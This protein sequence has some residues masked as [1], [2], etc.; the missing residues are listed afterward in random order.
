MPRLLACL[1]VL[2]AGTLS[3]DG[4]AMLELDLPLSNGRLFGAAFAQISPGERPCC[5]NDFSDKGHGKRVPGP[6]ASET[7]QGDPFATGAAGDPFATD[8]GGD[9]FAG[10]PAFQND[11]GGQVSNS[12]ESEAPNRFGWSMDFHGYLESRNQLRTTDGEF[13]SAR[14]RLWM[15][16]DG[17][18]GED[19]EG[20]AF[21]GSARFFVSAALDIDPS[22]ADLSDDHSAVRP[23]IQE[24]Y[25][26]F[27]SGRADFTLGRKMVRWGT[28][29]GVNPMDLINPLDYRD[30]VASGRSD[31]RVPVF[32]GQGIFRLP[33]S[34]LLQEAS[35]ECVAIPLARVNKLNSPGSAWESPWLQTLRE[36]D[37][38]GLLVFESQQR[39][40][41]V[42]KDAEFGFRMSSVFSGWDLSLLGFYG[43]LDNP[44]LEKESTAGGEND[45]LSRLTPVHPVFRAL[46]VSFAKGLSKSTIRGELAVKPDLPFTIAD[47]T[48]APGYQRRDTLEYVLGIDRTFGA[49]L[50]VNLQY[51]GDFVKNAGAL[52]KKCRD[53][54]ITFEIHDKFLQDDL[55]SGVRGIVSFTGQGWTCEPYAEYSLG[56]DWLLAA[57]MLVFEGPESGRFGQYDRNDIFTFRLRR[58]F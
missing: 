13:V 43:R 1:L 20:D 33:V 49:N 44:V 57:S 4:N 2:V 50:Y 15:D 3:P 41:T 28:G 48:S 11:E 56:D 51:F 24:A 53:D 18:L 10:E 52:A 14:Q 54:G 38:N 29:D 39:P 5:Q 12:G 26:V 42:L 31:S 17:V 22:A 46:G 35:L 34:G 19:R 25:A 16:I 27:D 6:L 30:P 21:L 40:E 36:A 23:H 47:P 7:I 37:H 32:L 58:S 45:G 9:P 55:E 8:S